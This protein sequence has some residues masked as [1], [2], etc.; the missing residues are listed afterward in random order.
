MWGGVRRRMG[1]RRVRRVEGMVGRRRGGRRWR[2]REGGGMVGWL[3]VV[4]VGGMVR[5]DDGKVRYLSGE[6]VE[7]EVR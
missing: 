2:R 7:L 4:F 6:G 1:V 5:D 3:V